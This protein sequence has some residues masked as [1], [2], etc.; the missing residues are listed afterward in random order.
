MTMNANGRVWILTGKHFLC[1]NPW[2]IMGV[3]RIHSDKCIT[4]YYSTLYVIP[5]DMWPHCLYEVQYSKLD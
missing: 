3:L 1:Q 4:T 2:V 5:Y